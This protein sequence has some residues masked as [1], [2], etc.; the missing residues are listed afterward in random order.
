MET[1]APTPITTTMIT[2]PCTPTAPHSCQPGQASSTTRTVRLT[3]NDNMRFVAVDPAVVKAGETVRFVITNAGRLPHEFSLGDKAFQQQHAAMMKAMPG[4]QHTDANTVT[5]A[6]GQKASL[7]WTFTGVAA[8]TVLEIA[9]HVPGH[10][11]A[12]MKID[13][14]VTR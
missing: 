12:G 7:V 9:C 5:I 11:E 1:G 4:M 3:L 2:P 14:R 8:G 6:P 13:L 10:Y